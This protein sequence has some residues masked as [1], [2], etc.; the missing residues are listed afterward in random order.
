MSILN[1]P[2]HP[3]LS[4]IQDMSWQQNVKPRKQFPHKRQNEEDDNSHETHDFVSSWLHEYTGPAI[5]E[6]PGRSV[7]K[8][9]NAPTEMNSTHADLPLYE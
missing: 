1:I 8:Q 6:T 4:I 9:H 5:Y 3:D 7:P 2:G